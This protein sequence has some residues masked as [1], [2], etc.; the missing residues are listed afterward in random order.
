M[1]NKDTEIV[2]RNLK[3]VLQF[4]IYKLDNNLCTPEEIQSVSR[5]IGSNLEM[6]ASIKELADFFGKPE[7]N[8]RV[9]INQKLIAKPKRKV[10]YPFL[11]FLN[12][13]PQKWLG[14]DNHKM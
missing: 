2:K 5:M 3:E 1:E 6:D 14:K 12:V 10:L 4:G 8:V 9:A 13:V 7:I 11:K